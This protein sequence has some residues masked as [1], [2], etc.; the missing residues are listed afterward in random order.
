MATLSVTG[1][2]LQ[3][4]QLSKQHNSKKIV[5]SPGE[6]KCTYQ[7]TKTSFSAQ[8]F[9]RCRKCFSQQSVGICASCSETC[10]NDHGTAYVGMSSAFCD[11]G[12]SCCKISCEIGT[13][14]TYDLYGKTVEKRQDWYQCHSCWGGNSQFGCCEVCADECHKGHDLVYKGESSDGAVCDCGGNQ[15]KSA[16]CTFHV[17]G[18]QHILQPFYRCIRCFS[19]TTSD[20]CCYQ[21]MKVCHAGHPTISVG[22]VKAFCDCGL[23]QCKIAC[24]I[25]KPG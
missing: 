20:G 18:K 15:H 8:P 25:Q 11:C 23:K 7:R 14:C 16:V 1:L 19:N 3:S 2:K 13:K 6:P 17:T 21:C 9:Y 5:S 24:K 4:S 12:L 10:H 22:V